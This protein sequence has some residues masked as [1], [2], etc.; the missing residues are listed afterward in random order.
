MALFLGLFLP[1]DNIVCEI[2]HAILPVLLII[3][4]N[5]ERQYM[6]RP[7][8]ML[9][10]V[11]III[12]SFILNV[13]MGNVI[14]TKDIYRLFSYIF[15]FGLFPYVSK[16]TFISNKI[17]YATAIIILTSQIAYVFNI[18]FLVS[19][20]DKLYPYT[21]ETRSFSS[22][23]LL[24]GA[25]NIDFIVNRRYGGLYHNPNQ[26]VRFLSLI[27]IVFYIENKTNKLIKI[28]PFIIITTISYILAG[29]RT[30]LLVGIILTVTYFLFLKKQQKKTIGFISLLIILAV[31]SYGITVAFEGYELRIFSIKEGLEGSLKTKFIWFSNFITQ[32]QSPIKFLFGHYSSNNVT[33]AYGIPL[34]DS[35]WG[36]LFYCFGLLGFLTLTIFYIQ[37]F[38]FKD[39][40]ITFFLLILLWGI[41]STIIF[42]FRM[43]FLFMLTL[44]KYY[45]EYKFA[46]KYKQNPSII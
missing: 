43:S 20:F 46:L 42:S 1:H 15:L 12:L 40:N 17:L 27:L 36:E 34:L 44:S 37:L 4:F 6:H 35:E 22:E 41:T 23:Y 13:L 11:A 32:L 38:R 10:L 21:G 26:L 16:N 3:I 24:Q 18:S 30:G 19:F 8:I 14:E 33:N 28:I 29:S 45:S 5:N 2:I 25:G 31:I 9:F 39:K 7:R